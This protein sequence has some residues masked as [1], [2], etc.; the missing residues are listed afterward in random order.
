MAGYV[1]STATSTAANPPVVFA[2]VI[3]GRIQWANT[4]TTAALGNLPTGA[5][6]GKMWFYSST[7]A[8][9]DTA[10]AAFF[11]DGTALGMSAGDLLIGVYS[12]AAST[13]PFFYIGALVTS[14]GSTSFAM[15]SS[16]LSS[17]AV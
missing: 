9:T 14:V 12:T 15:S 2:S 11:N 4:G 7:N 3:G 16:Y 10:A 13:T 17:T 8:A 1:G 5:A 6:G